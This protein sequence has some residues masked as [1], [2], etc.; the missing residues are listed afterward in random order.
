MKYNPKIFK[1]MFSRRL[2]VLGIFKSVL[3]GI[4]GLRIW[5]LQIKQRQ[6]YFELSEGNRI[7]VRFLL[8]SR[9]RILTD[10]LVPIADGVPRFEV[11][12]IPYRVKEL[13]PILDKL[14]QI[15]PI[16]SSK[17]QELKKL[18]KHLYRYAFIPIKTLTD[19]N[20]AIKISD[21][22]HQLPGID[23]QVISERFYP[24]F[25]LFCHVSGY[26]GRVSKAE[27]DADESHILRIPGMKM[28]KQGIEK[29]Y[30]TQLRGTAGALRVE[31]NHTGIVNHEIDRT[32]PR[33]GTD[34]H[35]TLNAQI[36]QTAHDAMQNETGAVVLMNVRNGALLS[37]YSSPAFNPNLFTNGI[38]FKDWDMLRNDE[39]APMNNKAIIGQYP[40]GSTFKMMTL[41]A[42]LEAGVI[43]PE[44]TIYCRGHYTLGTSRFH[45][46]KYTG[47]GHINASQSLM[48]SCDVY[49]YELSQR[50]GID[51]IAEVARRY[52]LGSPTGIDLPFEKSGLI[53]DGDWK[54]K[55]Y[56]KKW[57][58]GETLIS[59]IG[60]GS[61]L[62]TPLQLAVM[63]ARLA[64]DKMVVPHLVHQ[65]KPPVFDILP[66]VQTHITDIARHGM[67]SVVNLAGGT[68]PSGRIPAQYGTA[69]GKTGTAQVRRI[70]ASERKRGVLK[71]NQLE[72]KYRDHGLYVAFAPF[73]NPIFAV[74]C[75]AE[76]GGSGSGVAS[77]I[78]TKTLAKAFEVYG[79]NP[80]APYK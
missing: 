60:Q 64:T 23:I 17:I 32:D 53:P 33:S 20:E 39:H 49:F 37:M 80:I 27:Q 70:S 71:N 36:Q 56:G 41:I 5:W 74:A 67:F 28:G 8:P 62:T 66:N 35:L 25:D 16:E 21:K 12:L 61:V 55:T 10:D 79:L 42:G 57:L 29:T 40:P 34:L 30:D 26:V 76:H 50:V 47:H 31:V 72:W 58:M 6:K 38:S 1:T 54:L 69:A 15:T 13:E 68:A 24:N 43:K 75:V 45:C 2:V 14:S 9:G 3:L 7:D 78:A 52:G 65:D 73:E 18:N 19:W 63:T 77:P 48:H 44:E 59:S 4:L 46:W 51:K 11:V 22:L